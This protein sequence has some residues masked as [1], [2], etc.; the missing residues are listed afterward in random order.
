M[1]ICRL[2]VW[3]PLKI[4]FKIPFVRTFQIA[5]S[6]ISL[7]KG[8]SDVQHSFALRRA[9]SEEMFANFIQCHAK[10]VHVSSEFCA[11]KVRLADKFGEHL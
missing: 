11:G 10:N 9:E 8:K 5:K 1:L 4:V 2:G 6:T 3:N 7:F